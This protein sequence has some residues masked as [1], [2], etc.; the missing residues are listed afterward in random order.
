MD[1]KP[2]VRMHGGLLFFEVPMRYILLSDKFYEK[3]SRC[4]EILSKR[5]R[6]YAC[7]AIEVDGIQ[8]AIPF[9]HHIRHRYAFFTVGEAGLDYTK[10]VVIEDGSMVSA[11]LPTIE[12]C[13]FDRLKGRDAQ[14]EAG[15]R[16]YYRLV[17]KAR[18]YADNPHYANILRYSALQ[19][20]I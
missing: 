6:P 20:F 14:I 17:L 5:T 11:A 19:Y 10:A 15:M 9:R 12:Q 13:E 7:L 2:S 16:R 4:P 18:R 8:F 1:D 3:Y